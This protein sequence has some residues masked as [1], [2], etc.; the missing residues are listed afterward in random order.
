MAG[1]DGGMPQAL[2]AETLVSVRAKSRS[3]AAW[4]GRVVEKGS[5][6]G[7]KDAGPSGE[8]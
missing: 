7:L 5:P 3:V 2:A 1:E 4:Y 8:G 6:P